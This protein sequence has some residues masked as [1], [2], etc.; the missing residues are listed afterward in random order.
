MNFL[1]GSRKA[2]RAA[3]LLSVAALLALQSNL[4]AQAVDM[5]ADA[6]GSVTAVFQNWTAYNEATDSGGRTLRP[7]LNG[8]H[9]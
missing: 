6:D 7:D 5:K 4:H 9:E 2:G 3:L 1:S 8:Q